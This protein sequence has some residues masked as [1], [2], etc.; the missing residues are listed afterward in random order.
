MD[1]CTSCKDY[2][3]QMC[4]TDYIENVIYD[5]SKSEQVANSYKRVKKKNMKKIVFI[6]LAAVL[7]V[8]VIYSLIIALAMGLLAFDVATSK[9]KVHDN[10]EEYQMYRTGEHAKKEY[11][12]KWGMDESIW[13]K[14]ITADM[15]VEDYKMVYYNPWDAQFLGYMTVEYDDAA[16]QS[17][18]KRLE[19]YDSTEY[20]GY[21]GVTGFE[22]YEL[23]AM[24]AND[25]QGFVYALTDGE[26]EINYVEIIFCNYFMDLDY[27]EYIPE[28]YLPNGFD[29]TEDNPYRSEYLKR[30]QEQ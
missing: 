23:I 6:V 7:G 30:L 5:K 11:S 9:I 27:T 16:Y 2:Y 15:D 4:S 14:E 18:R 13:P 24:Y 10:I 3:N 29:A 8:L 17:E 12:N 22:D 25:Y 20:L 1:E 21:Y 19:N 26:N 28:N